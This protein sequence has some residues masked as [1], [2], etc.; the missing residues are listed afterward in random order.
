MLSGYGTRWN[1]QRCFEIQSRTLSWPSFRCSRADAIIS[2][3]TRKFDT[4][5]TWKC[6]MQVFRVTRIFSPC[7]FSSQQEGSPCTVVL[8]RDDACKESTGPL[9]KSVPLGGGISPLTPLKI[10]RAPVSSRKKGYHLGAELADQPV[11]AALPGIRFARAAVDR[12]VARRHR[13]CQWR[14]C[15]GSAR[16]SP[17][18]CR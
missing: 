11:G 10:T 4:S 12:R 15:L 17:I 9:L 2:N 18:A 16:G 8:S 7:I 3:S 14:R 13:Y 6:L 5:R 1:G